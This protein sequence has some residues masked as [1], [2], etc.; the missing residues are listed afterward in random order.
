MNAGASNVVVQGFLKGS[1][2]V[3]DAML[4]LSFT[5]D[6]TDINDL[7]KD[8]MSDFLS[9]YPIVMRGKVPDFGSIAMF[10]THT[11]ASLILALLEGDPSKATD[12]VEESDLPTLKEIAEPFMGGGVAN[13]L[14]KMGRTTEQLTDFE[15]SI[16]SPDDVDDLFA[17][18]G[19]PM[20]VS[21]FKFAAPPEIDS[22]AALIYT[23]SAEELVPQELVSAI[24]G[25]DAAGDSVQ[26]S[27]LLQEAQLSD[28]EMSD[29]LSGFAPEGE[30]IAE[31]AGGTL[32]PTSAPGNLDM[33][34]D[35][36]LVVTARLGS[37][38]LSIN[39]ILALGPGSII[40]VGHLVDEPVE[41]LVNDKLIARGD[42]VVVDEKFGLRITEI[43]SAE[44]R[45]ESLR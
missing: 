26:P 14:E 35:I 22:T 17:F 2:D 44:E 20:T 9:R 29:I 15:V 16:Q 31:V 37:V 1:F 28:D 4:S 12:T 34:L 3:F 41:L 23:Q 30:G 13:V 38:K 43:V 19:D 8:D 36:R 42:V 25:E 32:S 11:D 7:P 39:E 10:I 33:I 40:E 21:S 6:T 18:I 24:F 45:I 27:D 5:Y